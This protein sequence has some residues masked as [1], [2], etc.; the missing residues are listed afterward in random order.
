MLAMVCH[1]T[2]AIW[3]YMSISAVTLLTVYTGPL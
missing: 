3:V 1:S 2:L